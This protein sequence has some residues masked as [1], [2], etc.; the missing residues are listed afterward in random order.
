MHF[1]LFCNTYAA[2]R[3]QLIGDLSELTQAILPLN[4]KTDARDAKEFLNLI[5]YGLG[6]DP[7]QDRDF[8]EK[9]YT[10]IIETKRF[11]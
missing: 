11:M 10:Y 9:I 1:F 5:L 2:H 6:N 7:N 3:E 8:F 4:F